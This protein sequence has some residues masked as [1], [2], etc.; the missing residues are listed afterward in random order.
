L[1]ATGRFRRQRR[2]L[3]EFSDLANRA[4]FDVV[5]KLPCI[6]ALLE[7]HHVVAVVLPELAMDGLELFLQIELALILKERATNLFVELALETKQLR[8]G[9]EHLIQGFE[10]CGNV[11]CRQELLT[12]IDAHG[13]MGGD[14]IGLPRQRIR[15]LNER[16]HLVRDAPVQRDVL[17]EQREHAPREDVDRVGVGDFRLGFLGECRAHE[18]GRR[19]VARDAS[20]RHT[21]DEN[22]RRSI[23]LSRRLDNARDN[24]DAVEITRC[25]LF[26]VG[27]ALRD[28]EQ[29]PTLRRGGLD[30]RQGRLP[31]HEERHGDV[32]EDDDVA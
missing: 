2:H 18:T 16:D 27:A 4:Q 24:A 21:L 17:L 9:G 32:G 10:Q 3:A 23:G 5:R 29:R 25:R 20:A 22:S 1:R 14:A 30:G 19:H 31:A 8:L 26:G 6:Q 11:R 13:E 7:L 28:E 15:A 12:Y